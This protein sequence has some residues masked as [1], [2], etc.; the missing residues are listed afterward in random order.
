MPTEF[1]LKCVSCGKIETHSS[2]ERQGEMPGC[3]SCCGP[4]I[5]ESVAIKNSLL[6]VETLELIGKKANLLK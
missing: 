5:L 1:K 6:S 4:M 2:D 3:S